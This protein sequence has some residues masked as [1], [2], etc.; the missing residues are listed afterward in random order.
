MAEFPKENFRNKAL[1]SARRLVEFLEMDAPSQIVAQE[2]SILE[3]R[4]YLLCA[5]DMGTQQSERMLR[6][7]KARSGYCEEDS[8]WEFAEDTYCADHASDTSL[9][10]LA[11]RD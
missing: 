1:R 4:L 7:Q 9:I 11:L 6:L 10:M 2:A 8:C 3:D 5:A